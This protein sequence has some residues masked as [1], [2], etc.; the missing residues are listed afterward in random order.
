MPAFGAAL[1]DYEI[2]AILS[3]VRARWSDDKTGIP[4]EMTP[5]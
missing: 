5:A 4:V 3:F 1:G 2:A